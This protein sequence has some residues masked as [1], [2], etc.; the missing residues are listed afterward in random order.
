M[1]Y[2]D[3]SKAQLLEDNKELRQRISELEKITIKYTAIEE[4]IQERLEKYIQF[5]QSSFDG[6]A[7]CDLDGKIISC[8]NT[9]LNMTG[10]SE[11][12][13]KK[14]RYL[15]LTP[16]KWLEVDKKHVEQALQRGYSDIYDKERIRKDGTIF[17][18]S[19]RI[20]TRV[21]AQGKPISLWG[22]VRDITEHKQAEEAFKKG[23]ERY[24]LATAAAKVGVWDW[25]IETGEFYLDPNI[26]AILGYTDDEIPNDLG[27]WVKYVHPDDS[28]AVMQAAQAHLDGKTPGYTFEHRMLHKDGSIRWIL[29]RGKAVRDKAGNAIRMYGTDTDIT[30]RKRTEEALRENEERLSLIYN[31][32]GDVLFEINVESDGCYI[33]SSVNK[34]FLDATGLTEAKIIGKRIEEVIPETSVRMVLD[35]YKKAIKENIIVRWEE[36][37]VYPS[38]KKTGVVSVTPI[39]NIEG[40]CVRLVGSVHD[41]T[42]RKQ[43]EENLF[44]AKQ[45]AEESNRLKSAFLATMSHEIRTPLNA[46]NGFS[47]LLLREKLS[48]EYRKYI[49]MINNSG[50][51]LLNIINDVLNL[52][53]IEAGQLNLQEKPFSLR[54]LFDDL[55][56]KGKLFISQKWKKIE[57]R[58]NFPGE[59]DEFI[60]HD[61]QKLIQ[62]LT[63]LLNNAIKF[64]DKGFIEFGVSLKDDKTLEFYVKDT[65]RGIRL[66]KKNAIFEPFRQ[67][68]DGYT[69]KYGGTGL[70]LTISKRLVELMGGEIRL[71]TKTGD[72]HGTTFYF[73]LPYKPIKKITEVKEKKPRIPKT[74]PGKK[75]LIAEDEE[76]NCL[77][78]KMLLEKAD[79]ATEIAVNGKDAVLKYKDDPEIDLIIMDLRMPIKDGFQA[80]REIR[81]IEVNERLKKVPIIS[82]TAAFMENEEGRSMEAGCDHFL[83][84][85]IEQRDLLR[86][87]SRYLKRTVK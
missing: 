35:N 71:E 70:G 42:L 9:Y 60:E 57:L 48:D 49:E 45:K 3:K 31:S 6:I 20:W 84:K 22:I 34:A 12:E 61:K 63:N 30:E 73:T 5:F 75:I 77:Y 16:Q 87:V 32:V 58:K 80:T 79:Y 64:T 78:I 43:E 86:V 11:E 44:F 54:R 18:I 76:Y 69:R 41:I 17:P 74:H 7:E 59:I 62:I 24:S 46:I 67:E 2:K 15:D 66:D 53:V 26:K 38:G 83:Q 81:K 39:Q 8:N 19:I 14:L 23:E 40:R 47:D 51:S 25:N 55:E 33:F 82:L 4:D 50:R 28:E 21:D 13:I 29:V 72:D 36:T 65:G 56:S 37:S 27:V 52:S 85:P 10:H 68:E 1:K